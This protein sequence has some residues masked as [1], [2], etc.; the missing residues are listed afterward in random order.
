MLRT[1][2][3][4][5][6]AVR[7]VFVWVYNQLHKINTAPPSAMSATDVEAISEESPLL[8]VR[9]DIIAARPPQSGRLALRELAIA[10][11]SF[12]IS[13]VG[14]V[15]VCLARNMTEL[16]IG[17]HIQRTQLCIQ[18]ELHLTDFDSCLVEL[19]GCAL[20]PFG[21]DTGHVSRTCGSNW[22]YIGRYLRD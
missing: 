4:A 10:R 15:S 3:A 21:S 20:R 12:V 1:A 5:I 13:A 2:Q 6:L 22:S 14:T 19:S 16:S 8:S 11:W 7:P 17:E 9:P 18:Y